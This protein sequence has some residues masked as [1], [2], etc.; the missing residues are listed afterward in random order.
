MKIGIYNKYW[1]T[2]G[3]GEKHVG[4]IAQHLASSDKVDLISNTRFSI[5]DLESKLN[6]NLANC[7]EVILPN[8]TEEMMEEFS[9]NYDLWINSTFLS[10]MRSKAKTSILLVFFPFLD[11]ALRLLWKKLPVI[12]PEWLQ[13]F[14]WRKYGFWNTY[15]IVVSN[16]EF[17]KSW[18]QKWWKCESYVLPP[19]IDLFEMLQDHPKKKIILSV[20]RFFVGGHNKKQDVMIK[21]FIQMI[22]T[23]NCTG[24]HYHVCGGTHPEK[25]H[26]DY[27]QQLTQMSEGYPITIHPDIDRNSLVELYYDAKIF[28]HATGY[29]ESDVKSP[30]VMEHFGMT[31][32]EAMS[33][34]CIPI[35]INKAGQKEV[36]KHGVNGFVWDNLDDLYT[37]SIAVM[38][39]ADVGSIMAKARSTSQKYAV[40]EFN[41]S[42]VTLMQ[43]ISPS[44]PQR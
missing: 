17:T 33:A 25:V 15:D 40:A 30:E 14:F 4:A 44:A 34:G 22:K 37:L 36:I 18:V 19:P 1:S 21:A 20:G 11:T 35:V 39:S 13:K 38:S 43:K 31:T 8:H 5:A 27:L 32:V 10:S 9:A 3:G 23:H 7:I 41:R 6:L 26:Q 29:G 42:L 28:W 12:Q 16:S 24:W 2:C